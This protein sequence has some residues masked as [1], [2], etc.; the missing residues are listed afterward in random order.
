MSY[1]S[2]VMTTTDADNRQERP[3]SREYVAGLIV[4]EGCFTIVVSRRA[5]RLKHKH[6]FVMKPMFAMS[7]KDIETMNLVCHALDSW[8][9]SYLREDLT[10]KSMVRVSAY[11]IKR[12]SRIIECFLPYLTGTK[13]LAA[14]VVM[15]FMRLRL[16]KP[17]ASPYG[18]E[19]FALANRL[20]TEINAGAGVG[21]RLVSSETTRLA[22]ASSG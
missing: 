19:E 2:K 21:K 3:L 12:V 14:E 11:G 6:N 17:Q 1:T 13:R 8:G 22:A 9:L 7:M 10:A 16:S 15:E 5:E 20:R 4:G 18:E